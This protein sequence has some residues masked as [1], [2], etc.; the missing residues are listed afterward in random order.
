VELKMTI[1]KLI[2][3][4]TFIIFFLGVLVGFRCQEINLRQREQRLAEERRWINDQL[5]ALDA[6]QQVNILISQTQKQ[7][8]QQAL[9][10]ADTGRAIGLLA[11]S[12]T[13]SNAA[14]SQPPALTGVHTDRV[15]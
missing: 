7:L 4:G 10:Q 5:C 13:V 8:R 9:L 6:Y 2:I 1:L 12:T 14:P 11:R 15:F 3:L